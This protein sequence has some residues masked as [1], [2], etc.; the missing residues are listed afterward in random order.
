MTRRAPNQLMLPA[1]WLRFRNPRNDSVAIVST[2]PVDDN[3]VRIVFSDGHKR[4]LTWDEIE[5]ERRDLT[6]WYGAW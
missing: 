6:S 2:E 1:G 5:S 4:V 3:T